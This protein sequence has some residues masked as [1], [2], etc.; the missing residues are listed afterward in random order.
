MNRVIDLVYDA[1]YLTLPR[2]I[3]IIVFTLHS[4]SV[5]IALNTGTFSFFFIKKI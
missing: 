3:Q 1:Y 5:R 2:S 4:F